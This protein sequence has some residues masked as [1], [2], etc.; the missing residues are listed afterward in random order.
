MPVGAVIGAVATV[1]SALIAG[2]AAKKAA[3]K[4]AKAAEAAQQTQLEMYRATREDLS[5]YRDLGSGASKGISDLF[6]FNDSGAFD[7]ADWEA[8]KKTP[9]YTVPFQEGMKAI[10]NSAAAR[11]DLLSSGHLKKITNYAGNY[12]S[13]QFGSFMDRLYQLAG[14]GQNAAA[15]TGQAALTTGQGVASSQLAEGEAAASGTV[16]AANA[17]T[18][19]INSLGENLSYL[20]MKPT[21]GYSGMTS[22]YD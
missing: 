6:G 3:K 16:G 4:Q 5:P 20:A 1:G 7:T 10:D 11:G 12:A 15:R 17:L 8:Y 9:Y 18:S 13:K 22:L 19:G 14:L 21:S 2:N